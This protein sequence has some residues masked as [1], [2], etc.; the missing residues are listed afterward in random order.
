[1][2]AAGDDLAAG[3]QGFAP[4]GGAAL[5]RHLDNPALAQREGGF[6]IPEI[7][8]RPGAAAER[9]FI[10]FHTHLRRGRAF[11]E[12]AQKISTVLSVARCGLAGTGQQLRFRQTDQLFLAA[13]GKVFLSGGTTGQQ[14]GKEQ[15]G[16][17]FHGA[18]HAGSFCRSQTG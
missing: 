5:H 8:V 15:Q 6:A 11:A 10:L 16:Q 3:D 4:G 17:G 13:Q 14:A 7:F 2:Q 12:I 1:M 9:R 18:E